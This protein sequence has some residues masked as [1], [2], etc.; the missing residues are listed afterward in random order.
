MFIARIFLLFYLCVIT[1]TLLFPCKSFADDFANDEG[2]SKEKLTES[3]LKNTS[4]KP[5]QV[6]ELIKTLQTQFDVKPDQVIPIKGYLY[7]SGI[8]GALFVDHD[9]WYFDATLKV[10][11]S[12]ELIDIRELFLCDFHNGGLK[13]EV[14]YKWMFTFIPKGVNVDQLHGAVYGRGIG[15][16]AETF[17]G[18]E[19]S[20][21]PAQNRAHDVFHVALKAGF[22]GGVVFPK[23]EFKMRKIIDKANRTTVKL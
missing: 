8:N 18:L 6:E 11:G 16:V 9:T 14:A 19:G 21:M 2:I 20:W 13:I 15:L 17:L 4:L 3:I 7:A 23:M 22:G 1:S 10:P 12:E 5:E